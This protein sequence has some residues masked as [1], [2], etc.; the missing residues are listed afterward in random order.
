MKPTLYK[1]HLINRHGHIMQEQY[2]VAS[3]VNAA[4]RALREA[5]P[6]YEKA[7]LKVVE[8]MDVLIS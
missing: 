6:Y 5:S 1:I 7:K 3:G 4:K 2:V 8:C